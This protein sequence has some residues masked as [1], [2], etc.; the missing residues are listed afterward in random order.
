MIFT[1]AGRM[2]INIKENSISGVMSVGAAV[3]TLNKKHLSLAVLGIFSKWASC[4]DTLM[5]QSMQ[6]VHSIQSTATNYR[7][8]P[9]LPFAKTVHPHQRYQTH[10]RTIYNKFISFII[11]KWRVNVYVPAVCES[12]LILHHRR[13]ISDE[14]KTRI[15]WSRVA[16]NLL[17][18]WDGKRWKSQIYALSLFTAIWN[19][20]T[21]IT[22]FQFWFSAMV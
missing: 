19:L 11:P 5:L 6:S 20:F 1:R 8:L 9:L 18:I 10:C 3:T 16:E 7:L 12:K 15:L 14:K 13:I 4:L 2:M 17:I 21:S 22:I